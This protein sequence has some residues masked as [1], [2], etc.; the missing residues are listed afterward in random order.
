MSRIST[1]IT[2][3]RDTLADPSGSRWSSDRLLRLLDSA[4]KDVCRHSNIL[5]AKTILDLYSGVSD[6]T[7]PSNLLSVTRV[8]LNGKRIPIVSQSYMDKLNPEWELETTTTIDI[9]YIIYDKVATHTLKVWPIPVTETEITH[10]IDPIYGI[11]VDINGY[12][13]TDLYGVITQ[14]EVEKSEFINSGLPINSLVLYYIKA[15]STILTIEDSLEIPE[16]YDTALKFYITGHALRD[17]MD[18]QN[19]QMGLEELNFYTREL[20]EATKDS[21]KDS[22]DNIESLKVNYRG[23]F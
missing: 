22:V 20:L 2:L 17:D 9:K 10:L 11:T 1:I 16:I 18:A 14:L 23:A 4:Q 15:P 6:Y 8:M 3:A 21:M 19:R 12:S 5:K 13:L 7:L